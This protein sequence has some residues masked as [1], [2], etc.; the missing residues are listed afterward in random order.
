MPDLNDKKRNVGGKSKTP[1]TRK[2]NPRPIVKRIDSQTEVEQD[3]DQDGAKAKKQRV[4]YLLIGLAMNV[5]L[6]VLYTY[7][8]LVG[9]NYAVHTGNTILFGSILTSVTALVT[10]AMGIALPLLLKKE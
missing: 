4:V 10:T 1:T 5:P 6:Y 9:L 3:S 2:R 8:V 7:A